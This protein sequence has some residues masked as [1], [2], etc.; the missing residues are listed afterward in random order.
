MKKDPQG[1]TLYY[2]LVKGK[3]LRG[4]EPSNIKRWTRN[5]AARDPAQVIRISQENRRVFEEEVRTV[6][7]FQ[8]NLFPVRFKTE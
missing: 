7:H 1:S 4:L 5:S 8:T 3:Q 2:S 6:A